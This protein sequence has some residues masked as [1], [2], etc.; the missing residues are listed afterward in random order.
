MVNAVTQSSSVNQRLPVLD[1]WRGISILLVLV[2]HMLPLYPKWLALNSM[3]SAAGLSIFFFLSGYLVVSMLYKNPS[4]LSFMIRRL[5][6]VIPLAWIA[7]TILIIANR[8]AF[9]VGFANFFFYA[10][11]MAGGLIHSGEHLWSLSVEIQFYIGVA[12][13]VLAFGKRGLLLVPV[14]CVAVTSLRIADGAGFSIITWLRADEILVGGTVALLRSYRPREAGRGAWPIWITLILIPA[15]MVC[16][17]E[18]FLIGNYFRPYVTALLVYSTLTHVT[19]RFY[20]MLGSKRLRYIATI[21][22]ALYVV[23]PLTYAGWMGSGD[24]VTRYI[25][26][27]FSFLLTFGSA[28]FISNWIEQPLNRLGHQLANKIEKPASLT[29]H[30]TVQESLPVYVSSISD[31]FPGPARPKK[32]S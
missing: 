20:T 31:S 16:S 21:S 1:G 10:N 8:P 17:N 23:H 29:V 2:G 28:H 18:K 22:Y 7:V 6:R 26:R 4:I 24:S 15:L 32:S 3:V 25:K 5:F 9:E 27:I 30:D 14:A 11:L 13:V 12:I 19:G